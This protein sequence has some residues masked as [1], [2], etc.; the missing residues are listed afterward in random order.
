MKLLIDEASPALI[1]RFADTYPID[2]VTTNPS[3][4]AK[5]LSSPIAG[6]RNIRSI[7][8]CS[9]E[10]HVQVISKNAAEMEKE[11][12]FICKEI[13]SNT[14]VKIP[15]TPEGFIAIR[16]LVKK[17]FN[18]T[19]TAVYTP[20]QA[21]LAAKCG[22][23]YVAPYVNRIDNLASDGVETVKTIQ[24]ILV[25]SGL[26]TQVLAASFKNVRQVQ[27][28]C[29]YGIGAATVSKDILS[30]FANNPC[31]DEAVDKFVSDFESAYGYGKK[32]FDFEPL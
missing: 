26:K 2:G 17:G 1:A 15:A 12:N 31:V 20:M 23:N 5:S 29:R 13:G 11:A 14:F 21:Y 24:D 8:G 9:A 22:A 4:L 3:I 30:A 6:L 25:S 28:L 18:I 27:E 32:M 19:A 10:L 7:I 16:N